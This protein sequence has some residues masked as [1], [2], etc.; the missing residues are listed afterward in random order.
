MSMCSEACAAGVPVFIF[1]PKGTFGSKHERLHAALYQGGYATPLG[2]GQ[3]AFGGRLNAAKIVAEK[4]RDIF[5]QER[6]NAEQTLP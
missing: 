2:S 1:A 4:I 3:V 5:N 6:L